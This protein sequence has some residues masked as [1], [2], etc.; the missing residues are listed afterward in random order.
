[1][2]LL[3][4]GIGVVIALILLTRKRPATGGNFAPVAPPKA[5]SEAVSA[6]EAE[7]MNREAQ[8]RRA[9]T[10]QAHWWSL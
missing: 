7:T 8:A 10:L 1:M 4:V 2:L 9:G 6:A 3:A 5:E